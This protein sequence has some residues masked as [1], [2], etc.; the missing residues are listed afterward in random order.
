VPPTPTAPPRINPTVDKLAAYSWRLLLIGAAGLAIILLIVRLRVVLFPIIIATFLAVVLVPIAQIFKSR[1]VPKLAATVLTFVFFFG[2]L[3]GIVSL[4]VPTVADEIGDIGPT[5]AS[6]T[7]AIE[8][9]LVDDIGIASEQLEDWRDQASVAIRRS[10]AG[11]TDAVVDGAVLVGETFAGLLLA[12]FLAFFMVK[13][14]PR[15]QAF[16]LRN[17]PEDQRPLARRLGARGW[18]TLGGYLRGSAALGVVEGVI[19]GMAMAIVGASL[20][21]AVMTITFFAAFVPFIGAIVAGILAVAVTFVTAGTGPALVVAIVALAV[22]QLDNDL[23]APIVFGKALELHP[24][25]ILL[26]VATG[27]ALGGIGAAVL[28]VPVVA[29]GANLISEVR[30]P[31]DYGHDDEEAAPVQ[32][33]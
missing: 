8:T 27:A 18:R 22:Q 24:V 26:G 19:I 6:A 14:G 21:P 33:G 7:D 28:A 13:D 31:R 12:L 17:V 9:W 10:V 25:T 2:A 29:L 1:G 4:I 30:R 15:F 5:I 3:A 20:I 32:V 11:S 16:V 23:L